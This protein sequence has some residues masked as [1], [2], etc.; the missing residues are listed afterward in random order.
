[1]VSPGRGPAGFVPSDGAGTGGAG[2]GGVAG[3]GV[4]VDPPTR[5]RIPA[6]HVDAGLELL[7]LDASGTM[8]TPQDWARAGWFADGVAP[9]EVGPA[10]IAGHVDSKTGP[11][12]FAQLDRLHAGDLVEVQRAARWVAFRVVAVGRYPK[13]AFPT[14]EVY[15]P[16]PDPQLRLITCGGT[17]DSAQRS[18]VDNTVVYAVAT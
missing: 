7:H 3:D 2:G 18:Y 5:L 11:A 9:G 12:V 14:A 13:N 6:I 8:T 16:T 10:V 15:G 1:M 4:A 17:F